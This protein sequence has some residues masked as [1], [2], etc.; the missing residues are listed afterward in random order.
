MPYSEEFRLALEFELCRSKTFKEALRLGAVMDDM[1]D[2]LGS[3]S[4]C[5]LVIFHVAPFGI[6]FN[7]RYFTRFRFLRSTSSSG[8]A[9]LNLAAVVAILLFI[10]KSHAQAVLRLPANGHDEQLSG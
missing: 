8:M 9:L 4:A 5:T 3:Q 10:A 1:A 7:S 6:V 2:M